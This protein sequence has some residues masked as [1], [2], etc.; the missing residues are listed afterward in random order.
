LVDYFFDFIERKTDF[1][2]QEERAFKL[3]NDCMKMHL[4]S[5]KAAK[6]KKDVI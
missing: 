2:A 4:T 1:F 6:E 3:V 5:W